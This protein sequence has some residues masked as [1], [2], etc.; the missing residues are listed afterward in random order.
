MYSYIHYVV[1][2]VV[3][4]M[5]TDFDIYNKISQHGTVSE[6]QILNLFTLDM[7]SSKKPFV[8]WKSCSLFVMLYNFLFLCRGPSVAVKRPPVCS[9]GPIVLML[10]GH[11]CQA[12]LVSCHSD[13]SNYFTI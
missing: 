11:I 3:S 12:S 4:K 13:L 7:L 1:L 8:K 5:Y 9:I 2:S 6:A 10:P